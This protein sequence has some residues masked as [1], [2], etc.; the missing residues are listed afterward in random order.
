MSETLTQ[1]AAGAA[2][3]LTVGAGIVTLTSYIGRSVYKHLEH[4]EQKAMDKETQKRPYKP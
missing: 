3:F 2:V 1:I 4:S